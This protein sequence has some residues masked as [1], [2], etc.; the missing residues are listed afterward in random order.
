MQNVL[1]DLVLEAEATIA[2]S[3]R[4]ARALDHAG[5]D[6]SEK[7]L[8]RLATP[9]DLGRQREHP[10][11]GR[12]ALGAEGAP[13]I[14]EVYFAEMSQA[15]SGNAVLD[16]HVTALK[17]DCSVVKDRE[18]SARSL[19][20]RLALGLQASLLVRHAPGWLSEV[21]CPSR[22]DSPGHC[23]Y[24]SLPGSDCLRIIERVMPAV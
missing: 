1:A 5:S 20:D 13:E 14:L 2:M 17:R 9:L 12:A 6:E 7:L 19:A 24:G 10:V 3:M 23:Q 21:F 16:C 11:P 22:P 8:L 18:F 15:C 4:V